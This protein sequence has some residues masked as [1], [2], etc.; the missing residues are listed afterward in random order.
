MQGD[1]LNMAVCFWYPVK[2]D[3][4][5]VH[6][7]NSVRTS[8]F[9]QGTRN[10]RPCITCQPVH[11]TF[12]GSSFL[13]FVPRNQERK[14]WNW[15]FIKI[16]VVVNYPFTFVFVAFVLMDEGVAGRRV[17]TLITV[18]QYTFT[19]TNLD[20]EYT[21]HSSTVHLHIN[22]SRRRVHLSQ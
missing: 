4:S 22:Q 12:L 2:S 7:Y 19:L 5:Y 11:N 17:R 13:H 16:I 6:V 20:A 8:H 14:L 9:L 10:K 21:Y 18:V 3:L 1:H 15:K